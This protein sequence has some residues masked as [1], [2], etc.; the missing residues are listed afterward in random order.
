MK[1]SDVFRQKACLANWCYWILFC[2]FHAERDES[3]TRR[4]VGKWKNLKE[5][6]IKLL[7]VS[8]HSSFIA[9]SCLFSCWVFWHHSRRVVMCSINVYRQWI[10]FS[11]NRDDSN[12]VPRVEIVGKKI[13]CSIDISALDVKVPSLVHHSPSTR[14]LIFCFANL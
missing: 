4:V 1:C 14:L 10:P 8:K 12:D 11:W 7:F 13:E 5:T 2:H 6:I 3:I 9:F